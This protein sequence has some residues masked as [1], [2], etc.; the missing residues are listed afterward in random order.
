MIVEWDSS[1]RAGLNH[2]NSRLNLFYLA[3][4]WSIESVGRRQDE[5][6]EEMEDAEVGEEA[7][8]GGVSSVNGVVLNAGA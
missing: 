4:S 1:D 3:G 5:E 8:N 6:E 7:Q 2:S